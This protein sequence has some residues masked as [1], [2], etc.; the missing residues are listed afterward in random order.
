MGFGN[1][2]LTL[3]IR[4][5]GIDAAATGVQSLKAQF[6]SFKEML[7]TGFN[8]ELGAKLAESVIEVAREFPRAISEGLHYAAELKT[9]AIQTGLTA[10]AIQVLGNAAEDSG[11]SLEQVRS[12]MTNLRTATTEALGGSEQMTAAFDRLGISASDLA[13]MPLA[14]QLETVARAFAECSDDA[15][16]FSAMTQILGQRDGPRLQGMLRDLAESGLSGLATKMK[17]TG[18]LLDHEMIDKAKQLESGW[19]NLGDQSKAVFAEIGLY[20]KPVIEL[21]QW[22]A[23]KGLSILESITAGIARVA[24]A[25][26]ALAAVLKGSDWKDAMDAMVKLERAQRGMDAGGDLTGAPQIASAV[27]APKQGSGSSKTQQGEDP[28][29]RVMRL[30]ENEKTLAQRRVDAVA[31]LTAAQTQYDQIVAEGNA[32]QNVDMKALI[33]ASADIIEAKQKIAQIDGQLADGW[34]RQFEAT[35]E[36]RRIEESMLPLEEQRAAAAARLAEAEERYNALFTQDAKGTVH[37]DLDKV[38]DAQLAL[39]KA[40]RELF[41]IDGRIAAK[42]AKEDQAP[43][44]P[45]AS[46]ESFFG[47]EARNDVLRGIQDLSGGLAG[48]AMGTKKW[49]DVWRSVASN[50][51]QSIAQMIIQAVIFRSIMAFFP[52]FGKFLGIDKIFAAGGGSFVTNGPTQFTVGDNPGG[53]EL[54]NVIPLSGVGRTTVNGQALHM[55]GGGSALVGGASKSESPVMV[56]F[57]FATGVAGTVRQEIMGMMPALRNMVISTVKEASYRGAM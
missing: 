3:D 8:F 7:A 39:V 11:S 37:F 10:E 27:S 20:L 57:N 49:G 48:L 40:K 25:F 32:R 19:R 44:S 29:A 47:R 30:I 13:A 31:A 28:S 33:S 53:A 34:K 6:A 4:L 21:F 52:S 38:T 55:A 54:V 22:L 14:V 36:I 41:D 46:S 2:A 43:A 24:N 9:I 23:S 16:G 18:S 1:P 56:N 15:A 12:A 35:A 42:T 51:L 5:D 50:F 26:G 45:P 17:E